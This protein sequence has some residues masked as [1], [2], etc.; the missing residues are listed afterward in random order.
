MASRLSGVYLLFF[1]LIGLNAGSIS[2]LCSITSLGIPG[3][4]DICH[5]KTSRFFSEKSDEHEFLFRI[6]LRTDM[7]LLVDVVG[8]HRNLL[9]CGSLFIFGRQ[10]IDGW[11]V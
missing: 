9:I 4:F 3:I 6:Q 10:L 8:V 5:A 2:N 7:K 11:L 1:W